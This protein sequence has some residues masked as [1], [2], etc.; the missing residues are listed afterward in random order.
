MKCLLSKIEFSNFQNPEQ[1]KYRLP[2]LLSYQNLA[3]PAPKTRAAVSDSCECQI[4]LIARMKW[5]DYQGYAALHSHPNHAPTQTPKSPQAKTLALCSKCW[6][7][8]GKGKSH[9]CQ[10]NTKRENISN[11]VKNTS[12][13]SRAN[14]ASA[15]LKV[16]AEE[17]E[18]SSRGGVVHLQTGAKPLPVQIGTPKVQP[19]QPKFTHENLNKLQA[20]NNLSDKTML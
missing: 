20:A 1:T 5:P 3:P 18:V 10:K 19:R 12:K 13:K 7:E 14:V 6:S 15:T 16:I 11:I 2:P 8:I 4:C 9:T 17:Q